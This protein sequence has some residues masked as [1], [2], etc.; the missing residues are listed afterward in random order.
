MPAVDIRVPSLRV[1]RLHLPDADPN[2]TPGIVA[3]VLD[4][5]L[6]DTRGHPEAIEVDHPPEQIGEGDFFDRFGGFLGQGEE[7][8]EL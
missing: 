7:Q 6:A 1:S 4:A 8:A 5:S 3:A 2:V